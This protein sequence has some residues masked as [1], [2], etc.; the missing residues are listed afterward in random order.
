MKLKIIVMVN[1]DTGRTWIQGETPGHEYRAKG[2]TQA[3]AELIA[4]APET[5]AQ[6][7][8]LLVALKEL[9]R[10]DEMPPCA[11]QSERAVN[12][13]MDARAAI[14]RVEEGGDK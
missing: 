9:L 10:A 12:A 13:M 7:D 8:E 4:K 1:P 6:R 2:S 14:A 3:N 5:K 11:D